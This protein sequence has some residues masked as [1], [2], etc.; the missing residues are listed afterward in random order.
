[1][2]KHN[3]VPVATSEL[4]AE[5]RKCSCGWGNM[6]RVFFFS[7]GVPL[8]CVHL[9]FFFAVISPVS[10]EHTCWGCLVSCKHTYKQKLVTFKVGFKIY[11]N[12]D[13]FFPKTQTSHHREDVW[14]KKG[15]NGM[16]KRRGEEKDRGGALGA[17]W[18]ANELLKDNPHM[19]GK[20]MRGRQKGRERGEWNLL[21]WRRQLG[22]G[23]GGRKL[24]PPATW[25]R[26]ARVVVG[27]TL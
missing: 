24:I 7:K 3:F 9:L 5:V 21:E 10:L 4:M 17:L 26:G 13:L 2:R 8:M 16:K 12:S 22:V 6:Q 1:M 19:S 11:L 20:R 15:W 27:S 23:G 18:L 14:W 25:R